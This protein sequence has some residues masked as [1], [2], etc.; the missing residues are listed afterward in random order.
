MASK[1][2][3]FTKEEIYEKFNSAQTVEGFFHSLGYSTKSRLSGHTVQYFKRIYPE[4]DLSIIV[5]RHVKYEDLTGQTFNKLE[6]LYHDEK[7]SKE[8][9]RSYWVCKCLECGNLTSVEASNLK[10][11]HTSSCGCLKYK[12]HEKENLVGQVFGF[13]TAKELDIEK[14]KKYKVSYW[15]CECQCGNT[16]S[17]CIR[18]LKNG[19][20]MSCGCL[21]GSSKGEIII[22][23]ILKE[24][25]I[26]FETQ[27]TFDDLIGQRQLYFD[28][29]LPDYNILIEYQGQQHYFPINIFGGE[30]KF[31]KQLLYDQKKKE[32]AEKNN[33]NL[34]IIPYTDFNIIETYLL[35]ILGSTTSYNNVALSEAKEKTL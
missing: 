20:T 29:Y 32:Y 22:S 26:F 30:E 31:Q 9:K 10:S 11:G 3:N 6:V 24:L 7:L 21:R 1:L 28:F 25:D 15:K 2:D 18:N 16:T 17:V 19:N 23:Q 5:N 35:P 8:R 27:K 13:L 12:E 14:T 4:L 33:Y 34:I